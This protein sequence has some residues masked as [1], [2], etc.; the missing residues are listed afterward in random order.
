[1]RKLHGTFHPHR[2]RTVTSL[3]SNTNSPTTVGFVIFRLY[4][5]VSPTKIVQELGGEVY[6]HGQAEKP[7]NQIV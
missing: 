6:V 3:L 2:R 1:M 5:L 4:I 7:L